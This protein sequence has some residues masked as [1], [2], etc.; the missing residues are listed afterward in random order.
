MT[1]WEED[2]DWVEG[3]RAPS[4]THTQKGK[5]ESLLIIPSNGMKDVVCSFLFVICI[6]YLIHASR[7]SHTSSAAAVVGFNLLKGRTEHF[8]LRADFV[9]LLSICNF[10]TND[11][12]DLLSVLAFVHFWEASGGCVN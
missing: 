9:Y 12:F 2:P 8:L 1:S 4:N 6:N 3:G 10:F 5:P 11:R 7:A